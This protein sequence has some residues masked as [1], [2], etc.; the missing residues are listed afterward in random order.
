MMAQEFTAVIY[1][2]EYDE[3]YEVQWLISYCPEVDVMTQG[4]TV[5][6]A[7][8]ML[9]EAVEGVLELLTPEGLERRMREG[10]PDHPEIDDEDIWGSLIEIERDVLRVEVNMREALV[11]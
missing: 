8:L 6:E 1:Q 2:D 3:R 11:G 5:E 7:K 9:K 4:E 10:P